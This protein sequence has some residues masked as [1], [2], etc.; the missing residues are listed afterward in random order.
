M[1]HAKSSS[2]G[3]ERWLLPIAEQH[4]CPRHPACRF[5]PRRDRAVSASISSPVI[6][7]A[8]ACRHPAIMPLLVRS[9]TT[10]NPPTNYSFHDQF[11]GI[12]RLGSCGS[13]VRAPAARQ[14][15]SKNDIVN[16]VFHVAIGAVK[17]GGLGGSGSQVDDAQ[18]RSE[19]GAQGSFWGHIVRSFLTVIASA[20]LLAGC[21][22][23]QQQYLRTDG[24]PRRR[25]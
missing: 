24:A 15:A 19:Y 11:H 20:A 21:A 9:T 18:E 23:Q 5:G 1:M 2:H 13:E 3:K 25:H 14:S 22:H 17:C 16:S 7:N 6:A 8:T 10:R 4:R 12:D